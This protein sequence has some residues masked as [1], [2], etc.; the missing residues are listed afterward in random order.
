MIK[1]YARVSSDTQSLSRQLV[2]LK[3]YGVEEQNVY[4]EKKS[5]KNRERA[6]LNRLLS[7]LE[8]GDIVVVKELSRISRSTKDML[9]LVDEITLK[10]CFIKSLSESWLDTSSPQGTFLLTIFAGLSQL[11]REL[12]RNRCLEGIAV[13]RQKKDVVWGRPKKRNSRIDHAL[14]M[15]DTGNYSMKE[16]TEATGTARATIYRRLKERDI[17]A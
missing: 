2:A 11:E 6:E 7:E 4:T 5:G 3:E 13:A 12:I 17:T 1:G 10:G 8:A 14:Q 15:Y 9:A 16:I